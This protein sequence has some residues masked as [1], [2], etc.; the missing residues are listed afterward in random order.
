[1]I[2]SLG[3]LVIF[4]G[5]PEN[6]AIPDSSRKVPENPNNFGRANNPNNPKNTVIFQTE[7]LFGKRVIY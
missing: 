3:H 2:F 1:M 5:K 7:G 4:G 6:L